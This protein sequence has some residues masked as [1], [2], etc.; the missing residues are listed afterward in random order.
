MDVGLTDIELSAVNSGVED[1][2][3]LKFLFVDEGTNPGIKNMQKYMIEEVD[4]QYALDHVHNQQDAMNLLRQALSNNKVY[5]AVLIEDPISNTSGESVAKE[6]RL[7]GYSGLIIIWKISA[8]TTASIMATTS[9]TTSTN[10]TTTTT[11]TI[12]T[13]TTIPTTAAKSTTTTTAITTST[14]TLKSRSL[15]TAAT[16]LT[17]QNSNTDPP[18]INYGSEG[19]ANDGLEGDGNDGFDGDANDGF[20]GDANDGLNL[21]HRT[22]LV[23][24]RCKS[25]KAFICEL[26]TQY[27]R[28]TLNDFHEDDVYPMKYDASGDKIKVRR[29]RSYRDK[30]NYLYLYCTVSDAKVGITSFSKIQELIERHQTNLGKPT[31]LLWFPVAFEHGLRASRHGVGGCSLTFP[32]RT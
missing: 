19:G 13:T 25:I 1:L 21:S 20:E 30:Y 10:A 26:R 18:I 5:T 27:P 17:A 23:S 12:P 31:L 15:T 32:I 2:E 28:S 16:T 8:K 24:D 14:T 4:A 6:I 9:S 7:I 22:T 11:I 3:T 29:H